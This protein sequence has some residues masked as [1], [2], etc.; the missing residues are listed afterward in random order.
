MSMMDL[1]FSSSQIDPLILWEIPE[2]YPS[3][4]DYELIVLCW[5]DVNYSS[6]SLKDGLITGWDIQSFINDNESLQAVKFD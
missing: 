3:L 2:E 6:L 4:S 1:G 5:E